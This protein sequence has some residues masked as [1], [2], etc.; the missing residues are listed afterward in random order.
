MSTL[1]RPDLLGFAVTEPR[2]CNAMKPPAHNW[3]RCTATVECGFGCPASEK[4]GN[5]VSVKRR[6]VL[7]A[8]SESTQET[9]V[10]PDYHWL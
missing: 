1:A 6:L 8:H 2:K 5:G 4:P 3:H 10:R 7:G 9:C